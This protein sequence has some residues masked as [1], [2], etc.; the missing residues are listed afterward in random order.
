MITFHRRLTCNKDSKTLQPDKSHAP[1][2]GIHGPCPPTVTG[3]NIVTGEGLGNFPVINVC[4]TLV[5]S[6]RK[7]E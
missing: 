7:K 4:P 1:T 6:K 2:S 3:K 5:T